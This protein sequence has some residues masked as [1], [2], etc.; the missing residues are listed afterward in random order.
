MSSRHSALG[1]R[2]YVMSTLT[3]QS[4]FPY[5]GPAPT[6]REPY[7]PGDAPK[8]DER[9][10]ELAAR[11]GVQQERGEDLPTLVVEK[12]KIVDVLRVLKTEHQ[13]NLPLDLWGVDYPGREKRF[14]VMYQL[15]SLDKNERL[16][17]KV[18][19]GE[20]ETVDSA[21]PVYKGFDWFE[22]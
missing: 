12:E 2:H 3:R 19:V 14:D 7:V 1:T 8:M 16:R 20:N 13:Y 17:L 4:A 10:A 5:T 11:L 15:Y 22:R 21:T 9:G 18:R 6:N